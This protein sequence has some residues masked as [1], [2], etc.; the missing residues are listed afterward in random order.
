MTQQALKRD[1]SGSPLESLSESKTIDAFFRELAWRPFRFQ[2]SAWRSYAEGYDGLVHSAT[3]TG[4]TLAVWLAPI[5]AW[6]RKNPDRSRWEQKPAPGIRVIWLT[7]MRALA[8]DT[9]KSLR[10]PIEML[11]IPWSIESRTGDSKAST[12][13]RQMKR[14]PNALITTPESLSIM[15]THEN[16]QQEFSKLEL[17]V[18]DEWHELLGSKRGVQ[19]ELALARLRMLSPDVRTWGVSATL[20]SLDQ[21]A[22]ALFGHTSMRKKCIIQGVRCKKLRMESLIPVNMDRFPWSG[23]I[24]TK[25]IP[26]VAS[27]LENRKSTLVFTNT[28][29]QT[30]I[31]YQGLL[32]ERKDWAGRLALHHG[33]LDQSVRQWV[34]KELSAGKLKAVVCTSSLD[35]GVDFSEVDFIVQVGS[36]KGSARLLQRAGRSGHQ[37]GRTSQLAFV[38]TNA[39]ELI[40]FAAARKAISKGNLESRMLISKP[41]DVLVQHLVTIAIGGGFRSEELLS[42]VRSTLAYQSLSDDEWQWAIDF[43]VNGGS[44]LKAYPDFHRVVCE[45]GVHRVISKRIIQSHRMNVGTIASDSSIRIKYITGGSLGNVEESF[46]AKLSP[47]DRFAFAGRILSLVR[48]EGSIAYV[49]K[50]KGAPNTIPRWS[51]GRM[52]MSSE[53]ASELRA[54]LEEA[55]DGILDGPE[56]QSLAELFKIQNRWSAI[57]RMDELLVERI[58]VR[59]GYEIFCY[60]FEGRLVHEGLAAVVALRLS[61]THKTTFSIACNDYGFS[62]HSPHKIDFDGAVL[63]SAFDSRNLEQDILSTLNATEMAKRQFR[64]VARVAGLIKGSYP[65]ERK[66]ASHLQASSNLF[67]EAFREYDPDNL[68][69]Q[70]TH[71]ELLE[72]QLEVTRMRTALGR[73]ARSKML[74]LSPEHVSPLAFPLLVDQL[75][76][77]VSSESLADRVRRMQLQLEKAAAW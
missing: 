66:S 30:E 24:G 76:D 68:L 55:A 71:R 3:G 59:N 6:L 21:A 12:K 19:T 39:I 77:R 11:G 1:A 41:L 15:L 54:R 4:K 46:V 44:S 57:P 5:R 65:G 45:E 9:E 16:L 32:S 60:P 34:E 51:G 2:R 29:S 36:P 62:L 13:A 53:L 69:L 35:L 8:A 47:N 33:S 52:P 75:R 42:E 23:H 63:Q 64:Q 43:V 48:M 10:Q 18:V 27:R 56:M 67:Y 28:R 25:M 31:W 14:L 74:I 37:P 38:P 72:Q 73:I 7:P 22:L 70:Q 17:I 50:A 20:G 49:R 61:R 26:Q 40:E 58:K